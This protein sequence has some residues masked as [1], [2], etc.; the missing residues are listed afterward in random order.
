[1]DDA[2]TRF[3]R[4]AK[5]GDTLLGCFY[6]FRYEPVARR[7]KRRSLQKVN[8]HLIIDGKTTKLP[9]SMKKTGKRKR[10][11]SFPRTENLEMLEKSVSEKANFILREA[12]REDIQHNKFMVLLKGAKKRPTEV[13]TGSTNISQGGFSG[14]TNVGHG[15]A[16]PNTPNS[17]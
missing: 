9:K 13:W 12:S 10:V 1:M 16:T 4:N 8:V 17:I 14:Q 6:E 15:C 7:S 2:I 5:K 3:I 11:K